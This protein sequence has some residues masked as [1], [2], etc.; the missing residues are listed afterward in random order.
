MATVSPASFTPL[1]RN[2]RRRMYWTHCSCNCTIICV[3]EHQSTAEVWTRVFSV[4][5]SDL[6]RISVLRKQ[7]YGKILLTNPPNADIFVCLWLIIKLLTQIQY[8][9]LVLWKLLPTLLWNGAVYQTKATPLISKGPTTITLIVNIVSEV[10]VS[11]LLDFILSSVN[12]SLKYCDW[13]SGKKKVLRH[14]I[15][16]KGHN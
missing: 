4:V 12:V 14:K 15:S 6:P 3:S 7:L 2:L 16:R 13:D 1:E 10:K 8:T 9:D 11:F 5:A